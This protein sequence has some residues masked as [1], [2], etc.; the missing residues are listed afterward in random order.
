MI[1]T[2]NK[3]GILTNKEWSQ[4]WRT[5]RIFHAS[6]S[7]LRGHERLVHLGCFSQG[8]YFKY[9]IYNRSSYLWK[10]KIKIKLK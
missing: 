8:K 3:T 6:F 2:P 7:L 4:K 9:K 1:I 10:K 5:W